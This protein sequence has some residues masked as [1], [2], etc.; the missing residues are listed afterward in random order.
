MADRGQSVAN[1]GPT[2]IST[3]KK[4]P[5]M[6]ST[7]TNLVYVGAT[8]IALRE[9]AAAGEREPL[10]L[11][12]YG[13]TGGAQTLGCHHPPSPFSIMSPPERGTGPTRVARW[14][15]GGVDLR[16]GWR[17]RVSRSPSADPWLG[18]RSRGPRASFWSLRGE[19]TALGGCWSKQA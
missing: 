1:S 2:P 17:Q 19:S 6:Y 4:V 10:V 12:P 7:V 8:K 9:G 14:D 3:K 11:P 18:E 5:F 13:G 15:G 16:S